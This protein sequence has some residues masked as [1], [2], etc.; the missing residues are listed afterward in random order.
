MALIIGRK[1][2]TKKEKK[3][4][5]GALELL[6]FIQQTSKIQAE[7]RKKTMKKEEKRKMEKYKEQDTKL[8]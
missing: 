7:L 1:N 5:K 6:I 8:K 2:L 4:L 3:E